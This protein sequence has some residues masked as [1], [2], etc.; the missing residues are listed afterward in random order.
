MHDLQAVPAGLVLTVC[1]SRPRPGRTRAESVR[2]GNG[3][4]QADEGLG[5]VASCFP[6]ESIA[7]V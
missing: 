3:G 5:A 7:D 6:Q 2:T 1:S 4:L